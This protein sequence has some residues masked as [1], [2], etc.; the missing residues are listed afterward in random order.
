MEGIL[1][2]GSRGVDSKEAIPAGRGKEEVIGSSRGAPRLSVHSLLF[3]L[4]RWDRFFTIAPTAPFAE[5]TLHFQRC[6]QKQVGKVLFQTRPDCSRLVRVES[7]T[8]SQAI[9]NLLAPSGD[10]FCATPDDRLNACTDTVSISPQDCP[11]DDKVWSDC[12]TDLLNLLSEYDAVNVRCYTLFPR[13]RQ[14]N[15]TNVA[16]ISFKRHEL[17]THVYIGGV[18]LPI[19][20]YV[21]PPC[22]CR[23]CWR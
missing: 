19:W 14:E 23:N 21:P 18:M 3:A 2:K 10:P 6:L 4:A 11:I 8:Q 15:P 22:Q 13:G 12:H 9:A 7:E 5:N 1:S 17:P 16:R 20:P